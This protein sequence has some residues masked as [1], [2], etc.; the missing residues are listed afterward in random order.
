MRIR[1]KSNGMR[2]YQEDPEQPWDAGTGGAENPGTVVLASEGDLEIVSAT[3]RGVAGM[4]TSS[5]RTC[6]NDVGAAGERATV[7]SS[8]GVTG[9]AEL[10]A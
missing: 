5:A 2:R 1:R 3:S 9:A 4:L 10:N 8:V 6:N 7:G